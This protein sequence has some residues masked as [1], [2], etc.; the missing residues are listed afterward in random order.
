MMT[1]GPTRDVDE[2][3]EEP[4]LAWR[5]HSLCE[6]LSNGEILTVIAQQLGFCHGLV[7]ITIPVNDSIYITTFSADS[8]VNQQS[9][10]RNWPR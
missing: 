5:Q 8:T 7:S 1:L 2:S 10:Q 3:T 6:K 9:I 4:P